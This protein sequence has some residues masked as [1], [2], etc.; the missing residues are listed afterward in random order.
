MTR[1]SEFASPSIRYV[2]SRSLA[3]V[4]SSLANEPKTT[5]LVSGDVYLPTS[6]ES[7]LFNSSRFRDAARA[8]LS[9]TGLK[10]ATG[11][12]LVELAAIQGHS[13]NVSW[14][15]GSAASNPAL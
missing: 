14:L 7:N 6:F 10:D 12:F 2:Q 1:W 8:A 4:H 13:N 11:R 5:K 3:E 9:K 15:L